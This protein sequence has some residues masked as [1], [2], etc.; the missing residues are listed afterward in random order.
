MKNKIEKRNSVYI[1]TSIDGYISDKNGGIDWLDT[2]PIPA[3]IDMGYDKF[4]S[5]IDALV[6]GRITFE[7]VCGFDID[8]PY[9]KPVFI[10]SNTLTEVPEKYVDKVKIIKG[11]L[12]EVLKQIHLKGF[13]KLYIDGGTTIQS[14]L[15]EDLIDF[16]IITKIPILLG[17]GSPLFKLMT[18][19]LDFK[20]LKTEVFLNQIVQSQYERKKQTNTSSYL[21][22]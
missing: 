20:H 5:Q 13:Y 16:M 6:M 15:K 7:T 4:M 12:T 14:F 9:Q 2:I 10:L 11:P 19:P 22:K 3:N 17:G 21:H 8:W 18:K 1:A